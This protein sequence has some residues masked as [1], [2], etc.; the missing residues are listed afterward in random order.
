MANSS[1]ANHA[2]A[3]PWNGGGTVM[4]CAFLIGAPFTFRRKRLLAAMPLVLAMSLAGFMMACGAVGSST[5]TTQQHPQGAR[6][7]IVTVTPTGTAAAA[8]SAT[9]ANP[10]AVSIT[11]T[12]Q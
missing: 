2:P 5:T 8:G 3:I 4:F 6:T 12:V 11:V 7:Y 10:A 9:V 1:A